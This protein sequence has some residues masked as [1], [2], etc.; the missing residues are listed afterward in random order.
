[1]VIWVFNDFNL[2]RKKGKSK[3]VIKEW[4]SRGQLPI[5]AGMVFNLRAIYFFVRKEIT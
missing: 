2:T 3:P 1:M 5:N 4:F